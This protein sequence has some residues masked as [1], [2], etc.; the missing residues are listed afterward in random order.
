MMVHLGIVMWK[1]ALAV[2]V[3]TSAL[4]AQAAEV[5]GKLGYLSEWE[6]SAKVGDRVAQGRREFSGPLTVRHVGVCAPGRPVEMTGE[7]RYRIAGWA[8]R[9]M[10]ATLV[11]DGTECGFEGKF[12]GTYDGVLTCPQWR[13]VP[14][15]LSVKSGD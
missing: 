4:P 11:I 10:E 9:R 2:V 13:G 8:T 7:I 6:V 12:S 14:V 15:S 3:A 1:P 5:S